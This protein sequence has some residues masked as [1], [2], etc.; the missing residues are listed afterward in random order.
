[1]RQEHRL[2]GTSRRRTGRPTRPRVSRSARAC[3]TVLVLATGLLLVPHREAAAATGLELVATLPASPGSTHLFV[4]SELAQLYEIVSPGGIPSLKVRSAVDPFDVL[5]TVP[6][7]TNV[8]VGGPK[9]NPSALD[10]AAHL[11]Y[12]ATP[13]GGL[14]VFDGTKRT[15]LA[16]WKFGQ[17]D[18]LIANNLARV[19]GMTWD[20]RSERL[21]VTVMDGSPPAFAPPV[22]FA[23]DPLGCLEDEDGCAV[24]STGLVKWQFRPTGCPDIATGLG[25]IPGASAVPGRHELYLACTTP[26]TPVNVTG[27]RLT[28]GI[29]QIHLPPGGGAPTSQRFTPIPGDWQFGGA[30]FDPASERMLL[31]SRRFG[32]FGGFVYDGQSSLVIG[33]LK[34]T[35]NLTGAC[36]DPGT[37]RFYLSS[38]ENLAVGE[39]R[40]TPAQ[41][42]AE[43]RDFL[44]LATPQNGPAACDHERRQIFLPVQRPEG[45]AFL[46]LRDTKPS[47]VPQPPIDP[48]SLTQ[49]VPDDA[50]NVFVTYNAG[51]RAFGA[52][53]VQVGG[54]RGTQQSFSNG[55]FLQPLEVILSNLGPAIGSPHFSADRQVVL[56]QVGV[57]TQSVTISN[58][59]AQA[60][61]SSGERDPATMDHFTGNGN[62][63]DIWPFV[64][65]SCSE[66][67]ESEGE[68]ATSRGVLIRCL[69][70]GTAGDPRPRAG[71]E[72]GG[73]DA[74]VAIP[75]LVELAGAKASVDVRHD[76][77]LGSVA[78]AKASVR[79]VTLAGGQI[80][81]SDV[82]A[83]AT[84]HARG[85]PMSAGADYGRRIGSLTIQGQSQCAPCTVGQ[86]SEA[87]HTATNGTIEVIEP[88]Y[89]ARLAGGTAKGAAA[90]I[91]RDPLEQFNDQAINA[92]STLDQHVPALR[93]IV[94]VRGYQQNA[95]I[96]DL[97]APQVSSFRALSACPFCGFVPPPPGGSGFG[98]EMEAPPVPAPSAEVLEGIVD[99]P[100]T[101]PLQLVSSVDP[102]SSAPR[103][104]PA[105]PPPTGLTGFPG[106]LARGL[107][108]LFTEPGK[109]GM[110]MAVWAVL[111]TPV[112][113]SSRRRLVLARQ[114]R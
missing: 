27:P 108:T 101:L 21:Y 31:M 58:S 110:V 9:E 29:L 39:L 73:R 48:D 68:Q 51:G 22:I 36:I 3:V 15:V 74:A 100:E 1:M 84:S 96:V 19:R 113:L 28:Q 97:A 72:A 106:A 61:A 63:E 8:L 34:Q 4:D 40:P 88:K 114:G 62:H 42:G 82:E 85:V 32:P 59:G 37:G 65:A 16:N 107:M 92:M 76:P 87:I 105:A 23:L 77:E 112:Y 12:L 81:L 13:R 45:R 11:L 69:P 2:R 20:P 57:D 55:D 99:R 86:V 102:L 90:A 46:V 83:E 25:G 17:E 50:E 104:G 95:T 14:T 33:I 71:G 109:L 5:E 18:P 10:P 64:P 111:A 49:N 60:A 6:L 70:T 79:Q 89:E 44:A 7:Q 47:F 53:V 94:Q 24:S 54:L 52:R 38:D 30:I 26:T 66:A 98:G 80:V 75:G 103:V 41:T 35:G 91:L 56:A 67:R 43:H 78:T 93:L